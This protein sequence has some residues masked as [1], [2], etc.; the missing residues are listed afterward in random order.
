MEISKKLKF[1]TFLQF[2]DILKSKNVTTTEIFNFQKICCIFWFFKNKKCENFSLKKFCSNF[3][4]CSILRHL[5]HAWRFSKHI[6]NQKSLDMTVQKSV[7]SASF[8]SNLWFMRFA[9]K[10]IGEMLFDQIGLVAFCVLKF[11]KNFKIS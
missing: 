2:F 5:L 6:M 11:L 9:K 3:S 10:F 4:F 8:R 7:L 1:L